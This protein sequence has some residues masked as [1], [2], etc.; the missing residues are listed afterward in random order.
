MLARKVAAFLLVLSALFVSTAGAQ[1]SFST[2]TQ[3]PGSITLVFTPGNPHNDKPNPPVA[4]VEIVIRKLANI[5][6]STNEGLLAASKLKVNDV[7]NLPD[8][9]FD[10]RVEGESNADGVF[11]LAPVDQ[12]MYLVSSPEGAICFTPFVIVLPQ[13]SA[14]APGNPNTVVAYPKFD[15]E[16]EGETETTP[17]TTPRPTEQIAGHRPPIDG[18]VSTTPSEQVAGHRPF[19][20]NALANTGA[21]VIAILIAGSILVLLGFALIRRNRGTKK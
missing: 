8:D 1:E 15:I 2:P 12:G 3:T 13:Q 21:S 14:L 6:T 11:T 20:P 18:E 17:E 7:L 16:D 19:I 10:S 4:G 5:D 9:A